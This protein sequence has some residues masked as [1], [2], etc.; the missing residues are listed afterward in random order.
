MHSFDLTP[1]FR[2]TVGFDRMARL[3]DSATRVDDQAVSYPPY[4]IEKLGEDDYRISMAVAG[5]G[6]DAL[7][8][9]V[10]DGILVVSGKAEKRD[11]EQKFLHRGIARRAFERRFDLADHIQVTG[12]RLENGLLHIDLV[13]EVPE[14]MKPRQIAIK[15]AGGKTKS[16]EQK[17]A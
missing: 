9:T 2:S 4:N 17:A 10:R 6:E 1:L 3:L 8:V 7:D 16:I 12:A 11:A 14:A 13:R 5:F 15:T